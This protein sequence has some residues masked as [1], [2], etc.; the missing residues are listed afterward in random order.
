MFL[1]KPISTVNCFLKKLLLFLILLAFSSLQAQE[2]HSVSLN[3]AL[4]LAKENNK[5]I[6]KSQLEI[7]LAEQNIKERKELRLP[8][9][10]LNGMYSRITN[11]TE[12]KGSGFLKDKEVTPAIPEI[13]EVNS[14]F[15]MPIY[16]GNK[17]NNAIKI[18]NQENEIA[19]IK[20]E[21]TENDVELEVVA[22]YLAIYKMMEL[23]KI[24]EENIK[25]EKSR[26]KEVQSLSKH[27]T[28]TKNEVIRA[29][30]QLSDRELNA[31]TNSKNIKIAL[32]DLKT[33]IQLP[34]NEEIAIDTTANLDETNS[35]DPYDF[36]LNK[37]LQ[38][39]E[40]RIA[41]QE[42]KI[43]K[44]ELKLAKGNYLPTVSFFGNYGFYYPNYKFFPPN[45][46]LYTLGQV[47][48]EA[49]FDIS[50][51]YKNKTKVEQANT[52]IEWQQMQSEIIKDEVQD[53]LY[54]DHTQYQEILEKF[55]VVDKALDLAN[56]N[57]RIVKLKYL[58]QLVLITEM[59]DAD[60]ALLQAKYNKIST[61]LDAVL[62]HYEMLHTA[63][64]M[65]Q[66]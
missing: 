43:S 11:I 49:R 42:I 25:E 44:T 45:P 62:K 53:K 14:T 20:T 51:L 16:A 8:D 33:L 36:Y 5:K 58:N 59:V 27:G 4:K 9:I 52:K 38:N 26:L 30:L 35:L 34:E 2:V 24:F 47:G 41:S 21:K 12:F 50:G 56:E 60:N 15:K 23:Q 7:T 18:A 17:I 54:K 29:E 13:Y 28:V 46:Y 57:Y 6:L 3:E 32:H 63:G 10:E 64:I 61:H 19:K 22:N 1:K 37:A 66:I 40:M 55:V 48:I 39:E 65:P 31:L